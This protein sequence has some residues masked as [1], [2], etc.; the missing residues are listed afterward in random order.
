MNNK[1]NKEIKKQVCSICDEIRM[2]E[3]KVYIENW[4]CK[5]CRGNKNEEK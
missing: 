4:V 3:S 2:R 5:E 1:D